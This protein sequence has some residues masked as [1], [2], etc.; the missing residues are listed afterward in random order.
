MKKVMIM[1]V[2]MVTS[3]FILVLCLRPSLWAQG[4][5]NRWMADGIPFGGTNYGLDFSGSVPATFSLAGTPLATVRASQAICDD[6]GNVLFY[7]GGVSCKVFDKNGV[8]MP[9]GNSLNYPIPG[10]TYSIAPLIAPHPGNPDRYYIFYQ[11]NG[12]LYYSL[13]DMSLNGGMG[14]LVAK[15]VTINGFSGTD[16]ISTVSKI[17]L[18]KGC[19]SIWLVARSKNAGQFRSYELR[20]TGLVTEPVVSV[21]GN[22]PVSWYNGDVISGKLK[23]TPDGR[24]LAATVSKFYGVTGTAFP[25]PKGGIELYSFEQCSGLLKDPMVI[26]SSQHYDG[27]AFSPDNSKLYASSGT[28]VFQFDISLPS[29]ADILASKTFMLSNTLMP[30]WVIGCGFCDTTTRDI[31]D[32]KLAPDGKVYMGNNRP[33][34][35]VGCLPESTRNTYHSIENPNVAGMGAAPVTDAI[36]FPVGGFQT[37][38][39]L[40][41]DMV[42][43]PSPPDTIYRSRDITVCFR[44]TFLLKADTAARCVRWDDGSTGTARIVT[45]AGSYYVGYSTDGC[46]YHI[47]TFKVEMV[48]LPVITYT[49]F[50]CPGAAEGMAVIASRPGESFAYNF[51]WKDVSG[52]SVWVTTDALS[53]TVKGLNAG[54]N[55]VQVTTANGC[56]TTLTF[57]VTEL[58]QPL[59][60]FDADTAVCSGAEIRFSNSSDASVVAWDFG[61]GVGYDDDIVYH[62][63]GPAGEYLV[64]LTVV[65]PEG[66]A[67]RATSVVNVQE[68][69]LALAADAL[70]AD[71]GDA[72]TLVASAPVPFTVTAWEPAYLFADQSAVSQSIRIQESVTVTVFAQSNGLGC[73]DSTEVTLRLEP[74]M[75]VPTAFSP[76]GDGLND[77]F[78]PVMTGEGYALESFLIFNRWGQLVYEAYLNSGLSGWDGSLNGKP[79]D[80][81]VYFY[82]IVINNPSGKLV[83][84][85]GEVTLV[86]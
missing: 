60:S 29:A 40:P 8:M 78:F 85:K 76:N 84:K 31:G 13:V 2:L 5:G 61:N 35:C 54:I 63:F 50:S 21:L 58:P 25:S 45:S 48:P 14:D 65:N 80:M 18:V 74:F 67:H 22:F 77:M 1:T 32:L 15:N 73:R 27:L 69:D 86:R 59:A 79:V 66:C 23:A 4:E 9:N 46:G 62:T 42:S 16:A 53:D 81:G 70:I 33:D 83:V 37:G 6:A 49:G 38:L 7:T 34:Y 3:V 64:S 39:D 55:F 11:K 56:D 36:L 26:D 82:H 28:D 17:T 19:S 12:S 71:K 44:D 51:N 72:V 20:D 68:L 30:V 24:R 43:L 10:S 41:P 75:Q 47:D 57:S 52:N